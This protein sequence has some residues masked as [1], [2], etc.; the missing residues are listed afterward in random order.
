MVH[1]RFAAQAV[2]HVGDQIAFVQPRIGRAQLG[3]WRL[4][5]ALAGFGGGVEG[6][7]RHGVSLGKPMDRHQ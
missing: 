1:R 2:E 7:G 3:K 4:G 5:N 6:G